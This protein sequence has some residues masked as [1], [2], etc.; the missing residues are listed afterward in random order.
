MSD[1]TTDAWIAL[2]RAHSR[3]LNT[4][5]AALKAGGHPP[6]AWYDVLWELEQAPADGLRPKE[7]EPRLLLPQ[8][9]LSR[10]LARIQQAGLI[11]RHAD[12][13][14]GRAHR[15]T[16][17]EKGR[18]TRAA[19]WPVYSAALSRTIGALPPDQSAVMAGLL[20]RVAPPVGD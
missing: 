2:S 10:L 4:V 3:V 9:G 20:R 18:E 1:P 12:P 13:N 16:V 17:T 5:E 15:L 8:Y 11:R 19:M 7:L 6:L 14:D